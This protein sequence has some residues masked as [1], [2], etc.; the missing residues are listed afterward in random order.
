MRLIE[1]DIGNS[2]ELHKLYI[3]YCNDLKIKIPTYDFWLVKFRDPT[4]FCLL[5]KHGKKPFGFFMGNMCPYYDVPQVSIEA[6]F[7][8]RMFRGKLKFVRKFVNSGKDFL[9]HFK[10]EIMA[11]NRVKSKERKLGK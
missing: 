11:Y 5:A 1:A 7:V 10:I 9:K 6:V 2:G 8:R 4:F 3:E